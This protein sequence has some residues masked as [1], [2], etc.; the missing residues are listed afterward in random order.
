MWARI[1]YTNEITDFSETYN[2]KAILIIES[3]GWEI[4]NPNMEFQLVNPENHDTQNPQILCSDAH[5]H[6]QC[7]HQKMKLQR[8]LKISILQYSFAKP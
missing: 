1:N 3:P 4:R 7:A 8:G 6:A 2:F 5:H